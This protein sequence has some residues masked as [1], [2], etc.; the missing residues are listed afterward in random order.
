MPFSPYVLYTVNQQNCLLTDNHYSLRK[1]QHMVT[2]MQ[3]LYGIAIILRIDL[4]DACFKAQKWYADGGNAVGS[5]DKLKVLARRNMALPVSVIPSAMLLT[6][7]IFLKKH[8]R[9]SLMTK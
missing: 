3:C 5:H 1:V 6:K 9:S 8:S 7:N 2:P 4:F